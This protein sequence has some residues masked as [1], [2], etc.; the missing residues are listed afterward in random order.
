MGRL[1]RVCFTIFVIFSASASAARVQS[2][3]TPASPNCPSPPA[4]WKEPP[5]A[6]SQG[7]SLAKVVIASG[8]PDGTGGDRTEIACNYYSD[9]RRVSITVTYALPTDPNPVAD[10][11][12]GCSKALTAWTATRRMFVAISVNRWAVVAFSDPGRSLRESDVPGFEQAAH[13]LLRNAEQYAHTCAVKPEAT[14]VSF[15]YQYKF[16]APGTSGSGF[17]WAR[18]DPNTLEDTVVKVGP[19]TFSVA[20]RVGGKRAVLS[21][22]VIRGTAF[23]PARPGSAAELALKVR[24]IRSSAPAC[25]VGRVGSLI[26]TGDPAPSVRLAVCGHTFLRGRAHVEMSSV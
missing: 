26:M 16:S 25:S 21:F 8:N 17:L 19:E 24:V 4:G 1:A 18:T 10:F 3:D 5:G 23:R 22:S 11:Y 9:A 13:V 2:S 20:A 6:D 14:P 12:F 15:E 7:N